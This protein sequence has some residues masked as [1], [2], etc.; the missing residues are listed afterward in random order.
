LRRDN[1]SEALTAVDILFGEDTVE[2]FG[3]TFGTFSEEEKAKCVTDF[4]DIVGSVTASLEGKPM[5][6]DDGE[7]RSRR[8]GHFMACTNVFAN[9]LCASFVDDGGGR[10]RR[11]GHGG[12]PVCVQIVETSKVDEEM[13]YTGELTFTCECTEDF[14][15][16]L[17]DTPTTTITSVTATTTTT[18]TTTTTVTTVTAT[19]TTTP[20]PLCADKGCGFLGFNPADS[21]QCDQSC[22]VRCQIF[23]CQGTAS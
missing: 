17:C 7:R 18:T 2:R 22:E 4:E 23:S 6:D 8:G 20:S 21:C 11:K 19:T 16:A 3:I 12:S 9:E 10:H 15:G 14:L 5:D 13:E 1:N